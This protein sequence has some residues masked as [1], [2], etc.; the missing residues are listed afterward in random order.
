MFSL[1]SQLRGCEK[2]WG[3]S[4][5]RRELRKIDA[6]PRVARA[7]LDIILNGG[8]RAKERRCARV[9]YLSTYLREARRGA[10]VLQCKSLR[11]VKVS[12]AFP[13][14]RRLASLSLRWSPLNACITPLYHNSTRT[15]VRT[16]CISLSLWTFSKRIICLRWYSMN[17]S[18]NNCWTTCR[19]AT[20]SFCFYYSV[21]EVII[22][23]SQINIS[24]LISILIIKYFCL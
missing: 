17:T 9:V 23:I 24:L 5:F 19:F 11:T 21:F 7:R 4:V 22:T 12:S 2:L 3:Q 13:R 15:C 6:G 8:T 1:L 10:R 18:S 14:T 20:E 16:A